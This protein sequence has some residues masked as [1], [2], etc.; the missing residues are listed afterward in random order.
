MAATSR[1]SGEML[2]FPVHNQREANMHIKLTKQHFGAK[3][4]TTQSTTFSCDDVL[5]MVGLKKEKEKQ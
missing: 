3:G 2:I 1:L 4:E 5:V